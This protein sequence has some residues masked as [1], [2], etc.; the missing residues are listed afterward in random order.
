MDKQDKIWMWSSAAVS[1]AMGFILV[2]NDSGA[3][4]FLVILGITIIGTSTGAVQKW[5]DSNPHLTRWGLIGVTLLTILLIVGVVA[6]IV[7]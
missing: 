6:V 4:W 3:G 2:L 5:T 7:L 1:M